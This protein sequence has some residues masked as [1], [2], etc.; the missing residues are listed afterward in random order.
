M[1][2]KKTIKEK[3]ENA[4]NQ[5]IAI[6]QKADFNS[7][8]DNLTLSKLYGEIEAYQDCLTQFSVTLAYALD[9]YKRIQKSLKQLREPK[10]DKTLMQERTSALI[11][12]IE[13][14][15]KDDE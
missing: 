13:M 8:D 6:K 9:T 4:K 1:N 7:Y 10:N 12:F 2:F 3:I 5:L 14:L 15:L 11:E